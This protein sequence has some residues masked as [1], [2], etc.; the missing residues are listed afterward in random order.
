MH[1]VVSAVLALGAVAAFF[2]LAFFAYGKLT[3]DKGD[4]KKK[5]ESHRGWRNWRVAKKY[6][7]NVRVGA[8]RV[9]T[10]AALIDSEYDARFV[11]GSVGF[12]YAG[13]APP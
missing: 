1:S 5:M 10:Q 2:W 7:K 8:G 12:G 6:L 11:I 9:L 3:G 13:G 4:T